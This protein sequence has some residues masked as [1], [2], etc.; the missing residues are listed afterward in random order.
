[1]GCVFL[2]LDYWDVLEEFQNI[3]A[4]SPI[5]L[6]LRYMQGNADTFGG[7][8]SFQNRISYFDHHD[9]GIEV[10]CGFFKPF[11]ISPSGQFLSL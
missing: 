9:D 11:Q 5:A 1:M 3:F 6:P 8:F 4:N 2:L 7:N 10:P